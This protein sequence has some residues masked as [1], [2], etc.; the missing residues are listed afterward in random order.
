MKRHA[1]TP[2]ISISCHRRWDLS[3][4]YRGGHLGLNAP[5]RDC[6]SAMMARAAIDELRTGHEGAGKHRVVRWTRESKLFDL[7]VVI[8][9]GFSWRAVLGPG[10]SSLRRSRETGVPEQVALPV[11]GQRV[12]ASGVSVRRRWVS[13]AVQSN[14]DAGPLLAGAIPDCSACKALSIAISVFGS[15]RVACATVVRGRARRRV[16]RNDRGPNVP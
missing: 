3:A 8:P 15:S 4:E 7:R 5:C 6:I 12:N 9:A 16:M 10:R 14:P 13:A 11:A 1:R 2:R